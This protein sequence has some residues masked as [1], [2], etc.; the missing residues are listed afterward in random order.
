M[1]KQYVLRFG[2]SNPNT[3]VGL[4]PTFTSFVSILAGTSLAPPGITSLAAAGSTGL[5]YF[6]YGPSLAI[7]FIV[8]G[9]SSLN[10]NERF[11]TGILDPIQAVNEQCDV[12]IAQ[13]VTITANIGTTAS[14][15]GATNVDP[16]TLYGYL[17]RLQEW[18]EGDASFNKSTGQWEISSRG[19]S[20]LLRVK[21]LTNATSLVTKS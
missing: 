4:T 21:T 13:G 9:G 12:I 14:S 19:A 11:I 20:T 17:K 18:N 5:Y 6:T 2:T 7:S 10:P 1:S 3:Y 15:F 8:D 16:S